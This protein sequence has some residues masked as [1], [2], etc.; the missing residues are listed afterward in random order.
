M[1]PKELGKIF[2]IAREKKALTIEDA[3][4]KSRIHLSVLKDLEIGI[5]TRLGKPYLKSFLKKYSEFLGL[6]T[7]DILKKYETISS[8]V[9]SREFTLNVEKN[10]EDTGP[11]GLPWIT[12]KKM[13]AALA[14]SLSVVLIILVFVFMGMLRSRMGRVTVQKTVVPNSQTA[15]QSPSSETRIKEEKP[16]VKEEKQAG[17]VTLTIKATE[18]AWVHVADDKDVLFTGVI[19]GGT[20]KTWASDKPFT[21]WT[22]KA[23]KLIFSVNGKDLGQVAK[24]VVKDIRVS[25]GG[26]KVGSTWAARIE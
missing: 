1:T 12:E 19:E 11:A 10:E 18:K 22:G 16:E 6:N 13:Q 9:Q 5:L 21:V 15:A 8:K 23:E 17:S 2:A 4:E 24:G 26:I 25:S 7:D 14:A 3:S 20:E